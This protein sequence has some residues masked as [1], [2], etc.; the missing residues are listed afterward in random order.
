MYRAKHDQRTHSPAEFT[1]AH[2][3]GIVAPAIQ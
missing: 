1:L 3:A 2:T